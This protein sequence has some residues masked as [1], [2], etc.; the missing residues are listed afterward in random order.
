MAFSHGT[1]P[2][3][4]LI[5][6]GIVFRGVATTMGADEV[7]PGHHTL[8]PPFCSPWC[9]P[10]LLS[11][12]LVLGVRRPSSTRVGDSCRPFVRFLGPA[13]FVGAVVKLSS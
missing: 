11:V 2:R 10:F 8:R 1:T 6:L 3:H 5:H 9:L 13:G 12:G 7:Q 4:D